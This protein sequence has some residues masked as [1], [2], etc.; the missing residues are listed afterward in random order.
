MNFGALAGG[1]ADGL[2]SGSV[3]ADQALS[4]Q[5]K[6]Q[7]LQ[8]Y[9]NAQ[10]GQ[11]AFTNMAIPGM[12]AMPGTPQQPGS[13]LPTMAQ[14]P[15][16]GPISRGLESAGNAFGDLLGFGSPAPQPAPGMPLPGRGERPE[17]GQPSP[18]PQA[19]S[20]SMTAMPGMETMQM[21]ATAID[22]ANP[23]LKQGN[24]QAFA[25][26]VQLG[27]QRINEYASAQLEAGKNTAEIGKLNAQ[28]ETEKS[29][30]PVNASRAKY[31]DARAANP[32]TG[33]SVV[34]QMNKEIHS[35]LQKNAVQLRHYEDQKSRLL[36]APVQTPEIKG[37]VVET[38][39]Y[40]DAHRIRQ[41]D[42]EKQ[43]PDV[44]GRGKE[45]PTQQTVKAV[46]LAPAKKT[47]LNVPLKRIIGFGGE[48]TQTTKYVKHLQAQGVPQDE[49]N[50]LLMQAKEAL[51]GQSEAP[52]VPQGR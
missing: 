9:L 15:I 40:I 2:Q 22:K 30:L 35:Q 17:A 16:L 10:A 50:Y 11:R 23:G 3:L 49:I 12:S 13:G 39:K 4:R 5:L 1:A 8:E 44:V 21:V 6:Q 42:L 46:E 52:V 26:A 48:P 45:K 43:L 20:G 38:Q 29:K 7:Q 32:P 24:P 47:A 25:A 14:L 28:T 19:S 36:Q 34:D 37:L 41:S 31:F 33:K 27:M 51:S 18:A